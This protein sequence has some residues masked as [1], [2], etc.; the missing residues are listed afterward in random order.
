MTLAPKQSQ[1]QPT[2]AVSSQFI[3]NVCLFS[4]NLTNA[5]ETLGL[6]HKAKELINLPPAVT[7][8]VLSGQACAFRW[9]SHANR[10]FIK[11]CC[12]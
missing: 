9:F 11:G 4:L 10:R 8:V 3:G 2:C 6:S 1:M 7:L 5:N 12:I